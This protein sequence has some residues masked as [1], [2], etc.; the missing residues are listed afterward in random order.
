MER[1]ELKPCPFCGGTAEIVVIKK[2][3]KSIIAC[4]TP[5]CGFIRH[6]FNN[7]DTDEHAALRL[8]TAWNSRTTDDK[9]S[10]WI[11]VED[12]LPS[13][14]CLP[15]NCIVVAKV[16]DNTVVDWAQRYLSE[17]AFTK[18]KFVEWEILHDWDEGQ[19]CEITHWM[20]LPE[21][22]KMKGV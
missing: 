15:M 22:P 14:D 9:Q 12:R 20:P 7:G 3:F 5:H 13:E 1:T 6:S 21:P 8:T 4:T 19:G 16:G 17:N 10:E 11:S 2:G 18:E